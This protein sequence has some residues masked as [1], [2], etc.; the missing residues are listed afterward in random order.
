MIKALYCI[1]VYHIENFLYCIAL[2]SIITYYAVTYHTGLHHLQHVLRHIVPY[3]IIVHSAT[4]FCYIKCIL[5]LFCLCYIMM[6][7]VVF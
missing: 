5:L 1:L 4:V 3:C 7:C 6:C 2:S